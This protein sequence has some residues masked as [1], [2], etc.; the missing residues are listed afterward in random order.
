MLPLAQSNAIAAVVPE[1]T[2][3]VVGG[4]GGLAL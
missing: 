2:V 4:I 3:G 1:A